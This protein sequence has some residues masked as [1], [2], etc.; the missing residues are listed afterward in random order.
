LIIENKIKTQNTMKKL[1][2]TTAILLGIGLTS[3][4]QGNMFH[5]NDGNGSSY[6][7]EQS[8]GMRGGEGGILTPG[9]PTHGLT[10]NQNAP[11]GSGIVLLTALGAAYLVGKKRN[12][13]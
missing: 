5:R 8:T 9:L 10:E 7:A 13:E 4:A 2:I 12:E 11:L 1:I 3:F 6:F